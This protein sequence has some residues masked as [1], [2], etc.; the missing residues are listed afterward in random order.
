[1]KKPISFE[2]RKALYS[3]LLR[4]IRRSAEIAIQRPSALSVVIH[5]TIGHARAE[6]IPERHDL[7]LSRKQGVERMGHS[8]REVF[9]QE[10]L[11]RR[12]QRLFKVDGVAH[13][14]NRQLVKAG[15]AVKRPFG[16]H[17]IG[18]GHGRHPVPGG[19]WLAESPL[20]IDDDA[21]FTLVGA[22]PGDGVI[23]DIDD[24]GN[25]RSITCLIA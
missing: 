20:R 4:V 11:H 13:D 18:Q 21:V 23:L 9:V 12:A 15:D 25:V 3:A 1:M 16:R 2:L 8:W 19:D 6:P 7:M 5:S 24:P 22:P 10:E 17:G 14:R